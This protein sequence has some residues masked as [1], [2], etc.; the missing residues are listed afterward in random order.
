[1]YFKTLKEVLKS[2]TIWVVAEKGEW[3]YIAIEAFPSKTEAENYIKNL[4]SHNHYYSYEV[5]EQSLDEAFKTFDERVETYAINKEA[6][7][8]ARY[9][10]WELRNRISEQIH[11]Q[12]NEALQPIAEAITSLTY[13]NFRGEK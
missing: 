11:R 4:H 12:Y 7:K 10:D 6:E 2:K 9:A 1:M 8:I 3:S 13:K 5:V